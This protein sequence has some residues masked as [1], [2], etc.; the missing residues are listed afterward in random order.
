M[1]ISPLQKAKTYFIVYFLKFFSLIYVLFSVNKTY[2]KIPT[3]SLSK[4]YR[5]A[6]KSDDPDLIYGELSVLDFLYLLSLI[7]KKMPCKIYDLGS[8]D[9]KLLLSAVLFFKGIKAIG[10]E[11]V[12]TLQNVAAT[13]ALSKL[14]AISKNNCSL[15]FIEDSFLKKDFSD[16]NIIYLNAAALKKTTWDELSEKFKNL[17]QG[18]YVISVVRKLDDPLFSQIYSGMHN[19]SWGKAWVYIYQK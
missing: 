18:T 7:P 19:C 8:G 3:Y 17:K 16:A 11:T 4:Q 6:Q 9:G 2:Q 13:I 1:M 14:V 5:E 10:V 15:D 12:S